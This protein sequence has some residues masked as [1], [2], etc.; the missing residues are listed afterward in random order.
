[1]T[2]K[3]T[4]YPIAI[5]TYNKDRSKVLAV[6]RPSDDE[7]LPDVWGLP[8]GSLRSGET[9]EDAV[10]RAGREK[11]GVELKIIKPIGEDKIE[12]EKH[13]LRMKVF[14]AEII[15]GTP[16]VP[17]PVKGIT[18]YQD[19]KW[20]IPDELK[21]GARKGSLCCRVFLSNLRQEW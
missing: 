15:N 19:W 20:A 10:L 8:A 7:R 18:Q 17:Q 9:P 12:R 6:K 11:L 5:A 2:P 13:L 4:K 1:M 21:D 14:E 16:R 3:P